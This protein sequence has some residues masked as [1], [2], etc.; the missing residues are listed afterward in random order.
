MGNLDSQRD[1][2]HSKDYVRAM[3]LILNHDKPDDFVV[4]TGETRSIRQLCDIVF[5]K[6]GLDYR[7]YV[8]QNPKYM[9]PEELGYL[10]GDSTK[11]RTVLKWRPSYTFEQ[12]I[13]EML[14]FWLRYADTENAEAG[15]GSVDSKAQR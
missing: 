5:R 3:H 7:D 11:T 1:W 2:G 9:R 13:D 14:E 8:V 4:S 15:L 6:L 12:L 10:C